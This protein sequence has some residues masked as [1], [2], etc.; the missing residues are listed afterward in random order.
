MF[1]L[2]PSTAELASLVRGVGEEQLLLP[3]PCAEWT[4]RDLLSH[5]HQFAS[6]FTTNARKEPMA[7]PTGLVDDWRVAI[8]AAL[9]DVASAWSQPQ[10]W[11]GLVDAGGIEMPAADNAVV[12]VEEMTVHGWDLARAT[13]QRFEVPTEAVTRVENFLV[14]FPGAD[15]SSGPFGPNGPLP[16]DPDRFERVLAGTGRDPRWGQE[17]AL[18]GQPE[19]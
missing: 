9:G 16:A 2:Q 11:V 5:I 4:V 3:T 1:D 18:E 15:D 13:G 17:R 10:A 7:P 8:P 6:V 14:L 12:A 19:H